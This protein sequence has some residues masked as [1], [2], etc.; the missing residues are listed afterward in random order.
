MHS[1]LKKKKKMEDLDRN[2][3]GE[4]A[5]MKLPT[6][7]QYGVKLPFRVVVVGQTNSSKTNSIIQHWLGGRISFCKYINNELTMCQLQHCLYCSNEGM[8]DEEKQRLKDEFTLV[9]STSNT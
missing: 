3:N 2:G 6:L 4:K 8:S 1:F 9:V 7:V 5:S